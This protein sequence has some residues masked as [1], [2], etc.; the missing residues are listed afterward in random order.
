M[1]SIE[2]FKEVVEILRTHQIEIWVDLGALLGFE[3]EGHLLEWEEDIDCGT[4]HIKKE[5]EK[6]KAKLESKGWGMFDKYKGLAIQNKN[7]KIDIK[8]YTEE[9]EY[10]YANFVIYNHKWILKYCDFIGW[11]MR[12][13]SAEYKYETI[14]SKDK[15]RIIEMISKK[16]P[17]SIKKIIININDKVYYNYGLRGFKIKFPKTCVL[18]L[19]EKRVDGFPFKI[20]STPKPILELTYGK[21]WDKP[22]KIIPGTDRYPDGSSRY[23]TVRVMEQRPDLVEQ[24]R[25]V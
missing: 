10:I 13:Y 15:L 23:L 6:A 18:P 14:F 1:Q 8:Y 9:E 7:T 2:D 16:V 19:R 24:E 4:L 5:F 22:Q 20:P 21:N 11:F 25:Y 17:K 3:R 12:D